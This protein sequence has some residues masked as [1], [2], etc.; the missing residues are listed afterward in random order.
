MYLFI[1]YLG[2]RER[3]NVCAWM[4]EVRRER[5]NLMQASHPA[6]SLTPGCISWPWD[7]DLSQYQ[8]SH[9]TTLLIGLLKIVFSCTH[10]VCCFYVFYFID[11]HYD[12]YYFISYAY[13]GLCFFS[14]FFK[15]RAPVFSSYICIKI[16]NFV[17]WW[18]IFFILSRFSLFD[19]DASRY[20]SFL[21]FILLGAP[22]A[23]LICRLM[24]LS[25]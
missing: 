18:V 8:L 2:Y 22:W 16:A 20:G 1:Y 11:F 4:R 10:F 6:R 17:L 19:Y 21:I 25:F 15:I 24:L 7:H 12:L 3:E 23:S 13:F 14:S 5:E 9:H